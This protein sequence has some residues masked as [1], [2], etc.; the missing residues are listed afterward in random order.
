ML[1][2]GEEETSYKIVQCL[3]QL[4]S[5]VHSLLGDDVVRPSMS[6]LV[7]VCCHLLHSMLI[8]GVCVVIVWMHTETSECLTMLA[9][10]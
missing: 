5:V 1:C 4:S 7:N 9:R 10:R 2:R 3:N 8:D 6:T